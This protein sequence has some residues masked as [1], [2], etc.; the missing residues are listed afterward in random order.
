MKD[1]FDSSNVEQKPMGAFARGAYLDYAMYVILDRALPF[2]GDGL[3]P[4]QRRIVYAMNELGLK[5]TAK[6]KKSAR[7]VGDVLGKY[8][9]HGD[10]ACYEAMVL[11]AQDFSYRYPL[12]DGQGNWGSQDDPKSFA[13]M[14]Y[15][16]SRLSKS[17]E[18]LLKEIKKGTALWQPNFDG[19][20]KEPEF[21]PSRLPNILLNPTTGIAV[22]MATD[23]LPHNVNEVVDALLMLLK[24]PE[25]TLSDVLKHIKGPDMPTAAE[26][27]TPAAE[28]KKIYEKGRG[29]IKQRAVYHTENNEIVVTALPFNTSGA[30]V[31]T[32]LAAQMNAKKLP[33]IAD[34]RDESDHENPTRI[35][36]VPRQKRFD[37]DEIM[38][39]VCANTDLERSFRCNFNILGLNGKPQVKS[40][41]MIL[42]EWLQF[43]RETVT[44]RLENRLKQVLARLHILEGL[45]IAYLSIDEV[46]RVI[47]ESDT[48]KEDL[49]TAFNLSEIQADYIL[50]LKLRQLAKI[51]EMAIQSERD[52]LEA[53]RKV[54]E[55]Q[56]SDPEALN[57]LIKEE[58]EEDKETYGDARKS[59][60]VARSDAKAMDETQLM[61]SEPVTIVASKQL[62]LR[63][64]KGHKAVDEL[65]S[66]TYRT[67]DKLALIKHAKSNQELHFFSN[68]GRSFTIAAHTLPGAR[69]QGDPI[70]A[71]VNWPAGDEL[72]S[73]EVGKADELRLIASSAGY[74]FI[75][76]LENMKASKK[77]GKPVLTVPE[78]SSALTPLEVGNV[79][80]ANIAVISEDGYLL[81]FPAAELPILAKGKGNKLQNLPKG[82]TRVQLIS[83]YKV[84]DPVTLHT[85]GGKKL[86]LSVDDQDHYM[87]K[88]ASRGKKLPKGYS[89]I[90]SLS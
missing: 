32:D 15:T 21:L 76:E 6:Y 59:P 88:R 4:V 34:L 24:K 36:I 82:A 70:S 64:G 74:G 39:H 41:L 45:Q 52:E 58:L 18:Y 44:R 50:D 37:A 25:A 54:I 75:T 22:G 8:H 77:N 46:I 72:V 56:L 66:L 27:I 16:E 62:Y 55:N 3:K 17:A 87:G 53:E 63:A 30:K 81:I 60:L 5:S 38:G 80:E 51:E 69:G 84:G 12:V 31:L 61:S 86:N 14:R 23:L 65:G 48:P 47:R 89:D 78:G 90:A 85:P 20:L 13:A 71:K 40:L 83:T 43:R 68:S 29:S 49:I 10:S 35:V 73:I 79:A 19:T 2:I 33:M 11:M 42:N 28:L 7:T 57:G 26:V 9:P 1:N 67:G